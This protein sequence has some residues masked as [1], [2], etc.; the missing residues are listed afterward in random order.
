VVFLDYLTWGR[1]RGQR[2]ELGLGI[3]AKEQVPDDK[4]PVEAYLKCKSAVKHCRIGSS[5]IDDQRQ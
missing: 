4:G 1:R 3:K 5:F 2:A